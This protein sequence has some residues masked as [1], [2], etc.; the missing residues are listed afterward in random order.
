MFCLARRWLGD[1]SAAAV[2]GVGYGFGGVMVSSLMWPNNIAALGWLPF[3]VLSAA[4]VAVTETFVL[5]LTLG[6]VN[7]PVLE[8]VPALAAQLTA[9]L[10]V[11]WTVALNC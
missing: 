5:A 1:T 4:L 7:I 8:T 3:V 11:P 2:A 9:V 6:A 10:L